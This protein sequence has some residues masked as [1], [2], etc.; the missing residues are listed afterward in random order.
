[1]YNF[2]LIWACLAM[3]DQAQLICDLFTKKSTSYLYSLL[4]YWTSRNPAQSD[5]SRAFWAMTE[6]TLNHGTYNFE[7][8][9]KYHTNSP[10][11]LFSGK[12]NE[13]IF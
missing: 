5:L 3:S 7:S 2:E 8:K 9:F 4:R 11:R 1:M 10:F 6:G 13:K 12:S